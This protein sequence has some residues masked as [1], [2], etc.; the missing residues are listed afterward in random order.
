MN[1]EWALSVAMS[2]AVA[3]GKLIRDEFYRADGPRGHGS[4]ADIDAEAEADIRSA[5]LAQFPDCGFVGEETGHG[6]SSAGRYCWYVDPNDGTSAFLKGYRGSAVSIGLVHTADG[7]PVLGVVYSPLMPDDNGDLFTWAEGSPLRRNDVEVKRTR[8]AEELNA[9]TII[10]VN[11][12]GDDDAEATARIISPARFIAMPSIAYRLALVAAGEADLTVSTSAPTHWD[13]AGGHALVIGAG[14]DVFDDRCTP[15]RY[16]APPRGSAYFGGSASLTRQFGRMDWG[17]Y[18]RRAP[19]DELSSRYQWKTDSRC[20]IAPEVVARAQGAMLG[21]VAGDALGQQVE[22][23]SSSRIHRSYPDGLREIHDGGAWNTI[24]GQPTDD[25]ELALILAQTIVRQGTFSAEAVRKAYKDWYDSHPFDIGATTSA[26]IRGEPRYDSQANG[27]L[28]R[29]S[30]V[31][32]FGWNLSAEQ[33][34]TMARAD[35]ELTHANDICVDGSAVFAVAVGRAVRTGETGASIHESVTNWAKSCGYRAAVISALEAAAHEPPDHMDGSSMG[36][37]L[38]ALQNAFY[39]AVNAVNFE[40]GVVNTVMRGGDT[41]T[42]CAIAGALLGAIH[43]RDAVP[44][45]WRRAVL[46]CR[47]LASSRQPRPQVFWPTEVLNLAREL[48]S[49]RQ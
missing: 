28:M 39:E 38:I 25:S 33:V 17:F 4:H 23:S 40:A 15:V 2:A 42:N 16:Q 47:S 31:G 45:Q 19:L 29:I 7:L 36:W 8:L 13:M 34:A 41:D 46:S 43:G 5:L 22:F 48:T 32:V 26:G 11:Q 21:Q 10:I 30:P 27:A 12:H 3:A 49:C 1:F 9:E 37:V 24:A 6:G 14:G 35:A 20:R 18:G 44:I